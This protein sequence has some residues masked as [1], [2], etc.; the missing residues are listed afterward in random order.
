MVDAA[1]TH[2]RRARPGVWERLLA[3]VQE[4]GLRLGMTFLDGT[5]IR[6]HHQA[7]GAAKTGCS[8]AAGSS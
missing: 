1:Q 8:G 3:L 4:R 6:A 7:A 2:I 5:G